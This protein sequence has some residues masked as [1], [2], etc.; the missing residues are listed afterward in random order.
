MPPWGMRR[1]TVNALTHSCMVKMAGSG[2]QT[3]QRCACSGHRTL[4]LRLLTLAERWRAD[5]STVASWVSDPTIVIHQA[6][7]QLESVLTE[8]ADIQPA[9]SAAGTEARRD[10]S[11]ARLLPVLDQNGGNA[12]DQVQA[13]NH[14]KHDADRKNAVTDSVAND[15]EPG[16]ILEGLYRDIVTSMYG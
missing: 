13:Q 7:R 14:T 3:E 12:T 1:P 8:I 4:I 11:D 2:R 16:H 5:A 10:T 6:A 9:S 15:E